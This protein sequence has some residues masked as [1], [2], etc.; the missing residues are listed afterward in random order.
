MT[1]DE[2][3]GAYEER[4]GDVIV[5]CFDRKDPLEVPAVLVSGHAPFCWGRDVAEAAH[6][7]VVL[8]EVAALA[9][10]TVT[11]RANCEAISETLRD[12]HFLRKHGANAYYGQR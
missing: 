12:K 6:N 3:R 5:R 2:I 9:L 7:A 8:E 11:I 4:T 1:F 10:A